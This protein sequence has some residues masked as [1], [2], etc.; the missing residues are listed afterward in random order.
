MVG[1]GGSDG[2]EEIHEFLLTFKTFILGDIR[3]EPKT[4]HLEI[5]IIP[6]MENRQILMCVCVVFECFACVYTGA[7]CVYLVPRE[8]RRGR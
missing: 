5:I 4:N 3:S 1:D 6:T 2:R 8:V 7:P